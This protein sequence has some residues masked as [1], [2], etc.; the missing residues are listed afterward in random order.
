MFEAFLFVVS[1]FDGGVVGVIVALVI[2]LMFGDKPAARIAKVL[3]GIAAGVGYF[4]WC[5]S[6]L[7]SD[8]R[9]VSMTFGLVVLF[10]PVVVF[11]VLKLLM[12]AFKKE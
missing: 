6:I 12:Y 1:V 7:V 2:T 11:F 5:I 3:L 10:A 8:S 9:N 4:Y